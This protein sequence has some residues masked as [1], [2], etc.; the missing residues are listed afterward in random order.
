MTENVLFSI[1]DHGVA[2]ITLNRPKALNSLSYDMLKS[3]GQKLKEW[4]TNNQ[5]ALIVL[6]GAGSKGFCAGGDIKTLYEARSN[7]AALQ[8][9]EKFFE[10]EYDIDTYIYRYPKPIIACLDGIVMG[11][12]V[13]L[14]N[15]A[16]Y[17]IVTEHTK[18]AMPEMNIGF[19]PDVGAAYFLNQAPGHTGRYVALTAAV[20]KAADVLYINAADYYMTTES[21]SAFLTEIE[22]INWNIQDVHTTLKKIILTFASTPNA[23]STLASIL[24]NINTHFSF[25]SI[26]EIIDS[27]EKDGGTFALQ[28]KE[29][30]LSKSPFSL[31]VTLKQLSE[32]RNKSIEECFATDLILAKN[33][34]RH[35]DFFEGVRSVVIDKDQNPQYKY[36]KLSDVSDEDVNRFFHLLH[37]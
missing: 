26:E 4:E 29:T 25:H 12:G 22:N 34:M 35:D 1:G 6:K 32:G 13:G 14:T 36:K 23:E 33:F 17:R 24:E 3:I 19:F 8:H 16:T 15:G 31:K 27:L 5:I 10:E 9:A 20:L 21:L 11:G 30:L 28:T 2:T 37:V 18:W 7:E